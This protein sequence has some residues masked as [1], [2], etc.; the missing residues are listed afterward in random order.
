MQSIVNLNS[1]RYNYC[2]KKLLLLL[3]LCLLTGLFVYANDIEQNEEDMSINLELAQPQKTY[4]LQR[5]KYQKNLEVNKTVVTTQ[6]VQDY[7]EVDPN[8]KRTANFNKKKK[9]K[10]VSVGSKS[11]YTT[12]S[13]TCSCSDTVYTEYEKKNFKLN[14]GYTKNT[15]PN[16]QNQDKGSISVTPEYKINKYVSIQ[17]KFSTDLNNRSNKDEVK[18]D[19]RPFKDDRMD[20]GVGVGEK[21]SGPSSSSQ[22]NFSTNFRF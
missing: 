5:P 4:D 1:F 17:N 3:I 18:L 10:D 19:I 20:F 21:F 7:S 12:T 6:Q 16:H 2:M 11:T 9:I 8:Q 22:V 14:S 15:T 13:D